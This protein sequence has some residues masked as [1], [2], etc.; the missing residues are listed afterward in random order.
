[1]RSINYLQTTISTN[2]A[3]IKRADIVILLTSAT[4]CLLHSHH[5]KKGV[6][7]LDDTQPR[8][9]SSNLLLDRP[10][11]TIIDGGLVTVPHLKLRG[12]MGLPQGITF[13]CFAETMLLAQAGYEYDFSIG[14]PTLD[15]ADFISNLATQ[16]SHL[17]FDVAPDHS[18]GKPLPKVIPMN[19]DYGSRLLKYV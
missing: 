4:D 5:L 3:D 1:M 8:N 9:T 13:A 17:G 14:N 6:I 19:Y 16:Y 15:Q 12:S 11:V 2:L 18:F 10:D 7:I